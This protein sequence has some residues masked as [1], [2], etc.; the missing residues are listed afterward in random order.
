MKHNNEGSI[1]VKIGEATGN[2]GRAAESCDIDVE[3][4]IRDLRAMMG[5]RRL[6]GKIDEQR[7]ADM[8]HLV[9]LLSQLYCLCR[10][11]TDFISADSPLMKSI[12]IAL[13]QQGRFWI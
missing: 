13:E 7:N 1:N 4:M 3:R 6:Q 12:A 11:K 5:H 8:R 2:G 10:G 9:A